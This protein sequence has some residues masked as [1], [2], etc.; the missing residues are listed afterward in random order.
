MAGNYLAFAVMASLMI[1]SAYFEEAPSFKDAVN[2]DQVVTTLEEI[3]VCP[4]VDPVRCEHPP[5]LGL[6]RYQTKCKSQGVI[7]CCGRISEDEEGFCPCVHPTQCDP[8]TR[9]FLDQRPVDYIRFPPMPR[10]EDPMKRRC[11]PGGSSN[12]QDHRKVDIIEAATE[13]ANEE[14]EKEDDVTGNEALDYWAQAD[15]VCPCL[16][17]CPF[18]PYGRIPTDIRDFGVLP[19]CPYWRVRCC[20]RHRVQKRSAPWRQDRRSWS[21]LSL[22]EQSAY[23][24]ADQICPCVA[25]HSCPE[26]PYARLPTDVLHFGNLVHCFEPGQDRCCDRSQIHSRFARQTQ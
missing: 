7:R 23:T 17:H 12:H 10:C 15:L 18:V 14:V 11:C 22:L 3:R 4:C 25:A 8:K 21:A 6:Y 20:D 19:H 5:A 16:H 13:E 26:P 2:F 1:R 24:E 9:H